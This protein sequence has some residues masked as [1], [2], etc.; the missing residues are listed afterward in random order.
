MG[1][2]LNF[3][4]VQNGINLDNAAVYQ[5]ACCNHENVEGLAVLPI[6]EI[7]KETAGV[8]RD[9]NAVDLWNYEK[10]DGQGSQMTNS[11]RRTAALVS[12]VI[13]SIIMFTL[14]GCGEQSPEALD[15]RVTPSTEAATAEKSGVE[16][17]TNNKTNPLSEQDMQIAQQTASIYNEISAETSK[18]DTCVSL[19]TM[20]RIIARLGENGYAAVDSENQ[21]DMTG[22]ERVTAFCNAAEQ[23]QTAECTVIVV[24]NSGFRIFDLQTE[25]GIINVVRM[26]CQF[27]ENGRIKNTDTV[28]YTADFW[29]YTQEGYFLF[30]GNYFSNEDFVLTMSDASEHTALR[31]L[32]LNETCREQ[33]RAYILR[34]GYERNNLFLC[35]WNEDDFGSV[36]FYDVFDRFYP[37]LYGT[38]VPYTAADSTVN[39]T[40]Y[41]IPEAEF[42]TVIMTYFRIDKETLRAKTKY[43]AENKAYEYRPRGFYEAEY[44]DIPY[45]E[46]VGSTENADGTITLTINAVYP[47]DNTSKSYTH[48][49]V[50]YPLEDGGVQYV[51][52]Q[53]LTRRGEYDTWWH[54][55]RLTQ[56]ERAAETVTADTDMTDTALF[57]PQD[58]DCLLTDAEKDDVK[59]TV[60]AAA[61]EVKEIYRDIEIIGSS[62]YGS[63]IKNFTEEQRKAVV[64]LL[65]AAGYVSV[66]EDMNMENY[67]AVEDFYAAYQ[68]KRDAAVTVFDVDLDGLLRAVTFVYRKGKLQTYYIGIGWQE[69][70]IPNIK[71]TSTSDLAEINLTK[72]G[73]FIYQ[74]Q[75]LPMHASFRQYWRI[76]PLSDKC[77]ELTA[78]YVRGLS[79]VNY[80][81]LVTDW[82]SSNVEE[83]LMPCMF[84]D[85]YRI[86]MGKN[87]KAQNWRI[88]AE[89]YERI[90][91][92]YFPVSV[93][94]LRA[95]CG[96]ASDNNTYAYEMISPRPYPPF[97]EVVSYTENADNTI[98][99]TVDGVWADYNSDCAFTNTIVVQPFADGTFRYLSNSIEQRELELPQSDKKH[100]TE[101]PDL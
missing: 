2:D 7:L 60:L 11:K 55:D 58:G 49:T 63:N 25:N 16:T 33:N 64:K 72:K 29:Q 8:F 23:S 21:I 68:E 41:E 30:S 62:V 65:G 95:T 90:M 69:G 77:R 91:T 61:K 9:W 53:M 38:P 43:L 28:S 40:M 46:V 50:I 37:I 87:L 99:L 81:M 14:S 39:E 59:N 86:D 45:P 18:T 67:E 75:D 26:Y 85:I 52:N 96:Y 10:R 66:S 78:K 84:E 36:D 12:V 13:I 79:Y 82:D 48:R 88:P 83:I 1:V 20:R 5:N 6:E 76:K 3:W 47:H 34:I 74:Y 56:E 101:Y 44:P 19:A 100:Y 35:D 73:Y 80:N 27:D 15:T 98:T 71:D 94:T 51:S 42:E 24:M 4:K 32:P 97:G 92:T 54:S 93:E 57:F 89:T 31:V 70:G 22:A 17:A